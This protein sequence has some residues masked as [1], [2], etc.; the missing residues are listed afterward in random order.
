MFSPPN[1][2]RHLQHWQNT[3]PR[4]EAPVKGA[5]GLCPRGRHQ[6]AE[7]TPDAATGDIK[8]GPENFCL[9][10]KEG[11]G[12]HQHDTLFSSH[13]PC[14]GSSI[15]PKPGARVVKFQ[16]IQSRPIDYVLREREE[17]EKVAKL[18]FRTRRTMTFSESDGAKRTKRI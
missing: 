8:S 2:C 18:S 3:Q 17:I 14:T 10:R 12:I 15:Y 6:L 9:A 5:A 11:E 13:Y 4:K 1:A 7:D 16:E